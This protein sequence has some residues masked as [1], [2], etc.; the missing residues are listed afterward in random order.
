MV[1]AEYGIDD[2]L[3]YW[4][5]DY[6]RDAVDGGKK[7]VGDAVGVHVC[8]LGDEV[9]GHLGLAEPVDYERDARL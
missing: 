4:Q 7:I 8:G 6:D 9:C 2:M 3:H 1:T 5:D